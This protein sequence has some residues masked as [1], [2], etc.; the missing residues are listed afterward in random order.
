MKIGV[1]GAA[2]KTQ[3]F[4]NQAYV[5]YIAKAGHVPIVITPASDIKAIVEVCDGLL[6]PGGIDIEPTF[7]GENNV[8]SNNV[9]PARDDYERKVLHTFIDAKKPVL[10]ICRGFQMMVREFMFLHNNG[11]NNLK[12]LEYWQ[13]L[14][15]HN[16]TSARDIPRNVTSHSVVANL[17]LLYGEEGE[18]DTIIFVNSIHHQALI[19][20]NDNALEQHIDNENMI[21]ATAVTGFGMEHHRTEKNEKDRY[22]YVVEGVD[23]VMR[24]CKL[25]GVQWHPEELCDVN[26]FNSFFGEVENQNKDKAKGAAI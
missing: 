20:K 19:A 26:L 18:K 10:G 23:I 1:T 8:G 17:D 9:D 3:Y 21:I 11:K 2:S 13:H 24:G 15:G 5:D 6:L 7:Y 4:I 12:G 25:R 14:A 16:I 22:Q